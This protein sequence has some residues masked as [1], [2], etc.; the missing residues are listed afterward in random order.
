MYAYLRRSG[1]R[2]DQAQDLTLRILVNQRDRILEQYLRGNAGYVLARLR[3]HLIHKGIENIVP[4]RAAYALSRLDLLRKGVGDAAVI[5][6]AELQ[7]VADIGEGAPW[8]GYSN[9]G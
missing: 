8:R 2:A 4:R 3:V 1:H 7:G 5:D 9:Y 6:Q